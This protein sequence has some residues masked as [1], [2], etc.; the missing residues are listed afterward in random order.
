M[1][2]VALE[3]DSGTVVGF[4]RILTDWVS[5]AFLED[6]MVVERAHHRKIGTRLL[7][8]IKT[9]TRLAAVEQIALDTSNVLAQRFY[10]PAGWELQSVD[11][12]KPSGSA[13]MLLYPAGHPAWHAY[14]PSD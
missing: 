1:W 8:A 13:F 9:H 10:G 12:E 5:R 3:A 4:A 14:H 7:T 6:V 2:W 11:P